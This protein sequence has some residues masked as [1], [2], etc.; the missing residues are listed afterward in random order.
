MADTH[1]A[2]HARDLSSW[3]DELALS[4]GLATVNRK[5]S[6][7]LLRG[8]DADAGRIPPTSATDEYA[9]GARLVELGQALQARAFHR[10][11]HTE[12][13]IIDGDATS[14]TDTGAGTDA[15]PGAGRG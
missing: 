13:V 1:P 5:I 9:L 2:T 14:S 6:G 8:L 12:N 4:A 3:H 7:Y 15:R 11:T 10:A